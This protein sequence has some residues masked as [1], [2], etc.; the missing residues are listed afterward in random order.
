MPLVGADLD[1]IRSLRDYAVMTQRLTGYPVHL[2]R[3]S[4]REDLEKLS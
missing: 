3:Y 4:R 2:V 1:R